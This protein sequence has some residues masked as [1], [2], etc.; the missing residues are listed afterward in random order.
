[1]RG[2]DV[3]DAVVRI[4]ARDGLAAVTAPAVA[5]EARRSREW[6]QR[7]ATAEELLLRLT[8]TNTVAAVDRRIAAARHSLPGLLGTL[9]GQRVP[10]LAE[11]LAWLSALARSAAGPDLADPLRLRFGAVHRDLHART[12][13]AAPAA[14]HAARVTSALADGLAAHVLIGACSPQEAAGL[15][16]AYATASRLTC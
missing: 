2:T 4:I 13:T 7:H 6:V 3:A 8:L 10:D 15:L 12:A 11:H 16:A 5:E 1:M 9:A 14:D